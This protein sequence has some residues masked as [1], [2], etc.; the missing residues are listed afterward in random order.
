[1]TASEVLLTFVGWVALLL[2]GV[3]MVRTGITRSFTAQVRGFVSA[4]GR[5]RLAAAGIGLSVAALLQSS[6]AT[7]LIVS[8]LVT[9]SIVQLPAALAVMLGADVGTC[10]LYTSPSPRDRTRSRMPS[11]A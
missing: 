10:L 9:R 11:S 7:G 8:S 1:M 2:W 6:T 3:R 4:S 5:S